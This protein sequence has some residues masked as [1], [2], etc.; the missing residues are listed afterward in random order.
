MYT[1]KISKCSSHP[2]S[3]LSPS[4]FSPISIF[5]LLI[6]RCWLYWLLRFKNL[7]ITAIPIH[8]ISLSV[9]STS[10]P[11][12]RAQIATSVNIRRWC[13][14]NFVVFIQQTD[15]GVAAVSRAY[16]NSFYIRECVIILLAGYWRVE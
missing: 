16:F 6:I 10:L 2:T 12:S 15:A 8:I 1:F 5:L 14:H 13:L 3:I 11:Q 9:T 7:W 4:R